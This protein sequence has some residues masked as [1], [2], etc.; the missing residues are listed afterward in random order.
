M[1]DKK[2]EELR[3]AI[4]SAK[5]EEEKNKAIAEH[6]AYAA[7]QLGKG[8]SHIPSATYGRLL[9]QP[10]GETSKESEDETSKE[11]SNLDVK[12]KS[13]DGDNAA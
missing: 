9:N 6:N 2:H 5:T 7:S 12:P 1:A 13:P 10:V 3:L 4:V 11:E 8:G